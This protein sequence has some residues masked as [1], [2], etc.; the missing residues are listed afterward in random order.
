MKKFKQ[1]FFSVSTKIVIVYATIIAAFG[2]AMFMVYGL[3]KIEIDEKQKRVNEGTFLNHVANIEEAF[4]EMKS[5]A[6]ELRGDPYI[7]QAAGAD[8]SL[9]KFN[10]INSLNKVVSN[11]SYVDDVFIYNPTTKYFVSAQGSIDLDVYFR[12]V[13][14]DQYLTAKWA[15]LLQRRED[16]VMN[17]TKFPEYELINRRDYFKRMLYVDASNPRNSEL[18]VGFVVDIQKVVYQQD[19]ELNNFFVIGGAGDNALQDFFNSNLGYRAKKEELKLDGAVNAI[20]ANNNLVLYQSDS[21]RSL[22]YLNVVNLEM[23]YEQLGSSYVPILILAT[24]LLLIIA[25]TSWFLSKYNKNLR[26]IKSLLEDTFVTNLLLKS[27]G[28]S[29]VEDVKDFLGLKG[30][31]QIQ[32]VLISMKMRS[33]DGLGINAYEFEE[34][35]GRMLEQ[36]SIRF[37]SFDYSRL[38]TIFIID[39]K[40]I[41]DSTALQ[42]KLQKSLNDYQQAQDRSS[43]NL[44]FSSVYEGKDAIEKA[45]DEV[46]QLQEHVPVQVSGKVMAAEQD[47]P[48][49]QYIPGELR[50]RIRN[51]IAC[52]EKQSLIQWL[53]ELLNS[54]LERG[55]S[56]KNLKVLTAKINTSLSEAIFEKFPHR[57]DEMQQLIQPLN[58]AVEEVEAAFLPRLYEELIGKLES[59][60]ESANEDKERKKLQQCFIQYIEE[61]YNK[62][63][64]LETM[65][66]H[67]NLSAK[68][69]SSKFKETIGENF[70][71]YL[72]RYRIEVAKKLLRST[73]SKVNQISEQVG[74]NHV[75]VFIRQFKSME[76]V[77]P[78][79]YREIV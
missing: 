77:T 48:E 35:V 15:T 16:V 12:S 9:G 78:K 41:K 14:S 17:V 58:H 22:I 30:I 20:K 33:G 49:Y 34:Q 43:I 13:Y 6:F 69:A 64:Y 54:N 4:R 75:N 56:L 8:D 53:Q 73:L 5:R 55:I 39:A 10:Q 3:A 61:N 29:F 18:M 23:Y 7:K 76:G 26:N 74:Y 46:V 63:I 25:A 79:S 50:N 2:V 45:L 24:F 28:T 11:F 60:D 31:K 1:G 19:A 36:H 38:K 32:I 52:D 59:P 27:S 62:D 67:F 57:L 37:K 42:A 21:H 71:D 68:Y 66:A 72:N 51:S 65:A 47:W 40:S 70:T 44:F